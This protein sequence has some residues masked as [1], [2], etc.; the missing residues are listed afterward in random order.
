VA[1]TG[2]FYQATQP[3][4]GTV[5]VVGDAANGSA[6]AGNPV[7]IAGSDGTDARSI[8]VSTTGQL[9]VIVDTAPT[10]AVTNSGLT[11]LGA[12]IQAIGSAIPADVVMVGASDGT[13]SRA[14]VVDASGF[15][16][17]NVAAGGAG[18][19]AVYGP[20]AVGSAPANPP[21][22]VGGIDGASTPKIRTLGV[23]VTGATV[24]ANG[25]LVGGSDGTDLQ[26]IATDTSGRVKSVGA[27]TSGSA[28]SGAPVLVGGSDGTDART[29]LTDSNGHLYVMALAG[30]QK[31][32]AQLSGTSGVVL[33]SAPS[34]GKSYRLHLIVVNAS[35]SIG[36]LVQVYG[37]TTVETYGALTA[38]QN[39]IPMGGILCSEGLSI[40]GSVAGMA[41]YVTVH[42]DIITT[43]T[44]GP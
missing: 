1:V 40:N 2:T 4:S 27:A 30:G 17:V 41:Q 23:A 26:A 32:Q 33:L 16:K 21:E 44:I 42:Y 9:H 14:M 11:A 7:L 35:I 6:V 38:Y 10:T 8:L 22:L 29:M 25:V 13:D 31:A 34:S 24:P 28:V 3:I 5:T 18:G 19:G 20:T 15:L 37:T 12:S 43:P 39:V 36:N